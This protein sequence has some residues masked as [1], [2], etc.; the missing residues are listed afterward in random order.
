MRQKAKIPKANLEV[1]INSNYT[2]TCTDNFGRQISF[3]DITGSD[4][5]HLDSIL[6]GDN[7]T[8]TS[9]DVIKLLGKLSLQP[10][11]N[12]GKLVPNTIRSLYLA[13]QEHI[14][15]SYMSKEAWL[16]NCY[17][18]QNGSFQNISFM[19]SVPMSKFVAMC[20]IHK[21]AMDQMDKNAKGVENLTGFGDN[22]IT[23][24]T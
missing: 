22:Q 8:L 23:T 6:E 3:R 19:E 15:K 16:K 14:L 11:F 20:Q 21:E 18:I 7:P 17:A 5:E 2:I 4:L 9:K 13:V 1:T 12:F 24:N 10:E